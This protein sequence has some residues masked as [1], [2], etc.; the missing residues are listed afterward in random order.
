MTT[1]NRRPP[2][3]E[4]LLSEVAPFIRRILKK[5]ATDADRTAVAREMADWLEARG[6]R[7]G[8]AAWFRHPRLRWEHFDWGIGWSVHPWDNR[9]HGRGA[10]ID[11]DWW[12]LY[13]PTPAYTSSRAA[14]ELVAAWLRN[15][16]AVE[17]YPWTREVAARLD[18]LT[19]YDRAVRDRVEAAAN[20]LRWAAEAEARDRETYAKLQRKFGLVYFDP[21]GGI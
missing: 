19:E 16:V 11:N 3:A 21:G 1:R 8:H 5:R 4:W 20:R 6:D 10:R 17:D 18:R 12:T 9:G 14:E 15:G 2:K 7:G 13:Y